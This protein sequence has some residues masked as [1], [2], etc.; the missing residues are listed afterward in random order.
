MISNS[1]F[2]QHLFNLFSDWVLSNSK[3]KY[4]V[5][6]HKSLQLFKLWIYCAIPTHSNPHCYRVA[7]W[8]ENPFMNT[9]IWTKFSANGHIS[10]QL[11]I[12]TVGALLPNFFI[13]PWSGTKH[14]SGMCL[15][16]CLA[17]ACRQADLFYWI[18]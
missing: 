1:K 8:N 17:S 14:V 2:Q 10:Y 15:K 12:I 9:D 5:L 16:K 3:L 7:I 13:K 11:Q 4:S 6:F 18:L